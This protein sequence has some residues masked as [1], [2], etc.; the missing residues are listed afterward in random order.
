MPV[1]FKDY[2]KVLGI[3]RTADDA[4]IKRA[5]RAKARKLHPDVNREDPQAEDKFKELNEAYEVLSDGEKRKMYDRFGADWQRY[6]DAGFSSDT[7]GPSSSRPPVDDF[8]SWFRS[9][10]GSAGTTSSSFEYVDGTQGGSGRFSDF[11]NMIFGNQGTSGG[12]RTASSATRPRQMR[13]RGDDTE[14]AVD[15]SLREAASGTSR[16]IAL[17]IPTA[18]T[19]CGGTGVARGAMCPTCDGTGMMLTQKTLEVTIPKGVRTGSRIRMAG[20]GAQGIGGGPNGDVYLVISV[21][22][23][24]I[25]ERE[26]NNLREKVTVPLYTAILGGEMVVPTLTGRVAMTV[27]PGT[28]PGRVF[29]L[30][31]KGMPV[32]NSKSNEMGDIL[33]DVQIEIPTALS[34]E[35][36]ELFTKLRDLRQ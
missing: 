2:Y 3:E 35:E 26:G 17:Q 6:R 10:N 28:Q 23:D 13:A 22:P 14:V 30:R 18:C 7:A 29:R 11:F 33:V 16:H 27:P 15:V 8:E 20:Q 32:L 12:F 21:A 4:A 9:R 31:G 34:D 36:R 19:T 24:P 5:F 25:F 1:D